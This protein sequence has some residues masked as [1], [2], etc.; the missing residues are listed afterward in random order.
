ME[1]EKQGLS[2]RAPTFPDEQI[3]HVFCWRFFNVVTGTLAFFAVSL[4]QGTELPGL[5]AFLGHLKLGLRRNKSCPFPDWL[6]LFPWRTN[7][8]NCYRM[9]PGLIFT[10]LPQ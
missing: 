1:E 3:V 9:A 6:Q 7:L 5:L 4:A 8:L 10:A 2:H